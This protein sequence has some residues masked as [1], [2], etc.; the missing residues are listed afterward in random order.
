MWLLQEIWIIKFK[1]LGPKVITKNQ[2]HKITF[3][4]WLFQAKV[5]NKKSLSKNKFQIWLF[6]KNWIVKF[7]NLRPKVIMKNQI[8][9]LEFLL[10]CLLTI[11]AGRLQTS[12]LK[13]KVCKIGFGMPCVLVEREGSSMQQATRGLRAFAQTVLTVF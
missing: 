10:L 4:I 11:A 1:N 9:L 3:Q 8:C 12:G 7:K 13:M 5:I 2:I 6:R